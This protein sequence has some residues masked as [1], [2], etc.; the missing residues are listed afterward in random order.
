MGRLGEHPAGRGL[1]LPRIGERERL[2]RW[3][4]MNLGWRQGNNAEDIGGEHV[5]FG[6]VDVEA[7][8][9]FG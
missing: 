5:D 1:K 8:R 7:G 9:L 2:G 4:G 6:V 3:E